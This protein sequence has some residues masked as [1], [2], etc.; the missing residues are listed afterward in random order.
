MKY[1]L[2]Y[3]MLMRLSNRHKYGILK[4][5]RSWP[6][7]LFPPQF[8]DPCGTAVPGD[9]AICRT[10]TSPTYSHHR[11]PAAPRHRRPL[12]SLNMTPQPPTLHRPSG[13][14]PPPSQNP[15]IVVGDQAPNP[16]QNR[17]P[18]LDPPHRRRQAAP[19]LWTVSPVL[20]LSSL[21]PPSAPSPSLSTREWWARLRRAARSRV[22]KIFV[23][24]KILWASV[25]DAHIY[26]SK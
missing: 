13:R 1:Y 25:K 18:K 6:D 3:T 8:P 23:K 19:S 16:Q 11:P 20:D 4:K 2:L 15:S 17:N 21:L 7:L 14:A 9:G 26:S 5:G 12:T 10:V 22:R 24:K